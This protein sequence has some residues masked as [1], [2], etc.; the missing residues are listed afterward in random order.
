MYPFYYHPSQLRIQ[1]VQ[2]NKLSIIE[3]EG[4]GEVEIKPNL[5]IIP[6]GVMTESKNARA[7]QEEN[8]R[9]TSQVIQSLQQVGIPSKNIETVSYH[10]S[11]KYVFMDNKRVFEGFEV[12]HLLSVTSEDIENAGI[13]YDTAFANGANIA[14]SPRFIVSNEDIYQLMALQKAVED[15]I[16]KAEAV[17]NTLKVTLNKIPLK[18]EESSPPQILSDQVMF[19]AIAS[20]P[21]HARD[22]K[23]TARIR[24]VFTFM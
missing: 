10:V 23:I 18:V 5:V 21:I 1:G 17:S 15:A 19:Q 8:A 11:P 12:V 4:F 14:E 6:V 24:A 7:A 13:I 16:N 2:R 9:V 22:V 20:T 3:V